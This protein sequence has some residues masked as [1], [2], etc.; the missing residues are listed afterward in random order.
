VFDRL[1]V[2]PPGKYDI[3]TI[4]HVFEHLTDHAAALKA[5]RGLLG[6]RSH[7]YIEVPNARSLRARLSLPLFSRRFGFDERHR[8]FPIHLSYFD[9]STLRRLVEEQEFTVERL[10]T[11][12]I[13]LEE[14]L[15]RPEQK[16]RI[17]MPV[18]SPSASP[19]RL[20]LGRMRRLIKMMI[21]GSFLGENLGVICRSND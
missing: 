2:L 18:D 8:A 4:N 20:R 16:N 21:L 13:G 14:L 17:Q 15:V 7:V 9:S 5:V 19:P 3:I 1:D 6:P 11:N 12:G 10:L